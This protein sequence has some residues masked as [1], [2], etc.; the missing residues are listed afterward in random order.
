MVRGPYRP[1][2]FKGPLEITIH[3]AFALG[4]AVEYEPHLFTEKEIQISVV[5]G[6]FYFMWTH[7]WGHK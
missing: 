2:G 1:L 4:F 6:P 3:R 5:V 7:R